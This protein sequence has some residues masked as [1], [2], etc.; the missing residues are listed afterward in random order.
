MTRFAA[1]ARSLCRNLTR[2]T[3]LDAEMHDEIRLHLELEAERLVRDEGLAP[4]EAR[5]RAFVAFGGVEKVQAG[6][7]ATRAPAGR[8]RRSFRIPGSAS[9][10]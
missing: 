3:D 2:T 8:S 9:E 1:L 4:A 6:T 5:R 10:C 7:A